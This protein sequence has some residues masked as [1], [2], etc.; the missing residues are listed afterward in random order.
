MHI[1][2][3]AQCEGTTSATQ[4]VAQEPLLQ[5]IYKDSLSATSAIRMNVEPSTRTKRKRTAISVNSLRTCLCG[6]QIDESE[7]NIVKC[8]RA[9]CETQWVR[10]FL[11]PKYQLRHPLFSSTSCVH[12][13]HLKREIGH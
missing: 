1:I 2:Q 13:S 9:G 7:P 11:F 8:S 4:T 5:H 6:L 3:Q 12:R 10:G